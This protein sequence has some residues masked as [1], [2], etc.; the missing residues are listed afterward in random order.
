MTTG[1]YVVSSVTTADVAPHERAEFWSEHIMA[2]HVLLDWDFP[3]T[4]D[5]RGATVRQS[6]DT[7]QLMRWS[8]DHDHRLSRTPRQVRQDPDDDYRL[9][10]LHAGDAVVRQGDDQ[11]LL[12]TGTACLFPVSSPFVL[13]YLSPQNGLVMTIP[14]RELDGPLNRKTPLATGLDLST[15]LGRVVGNMLTR[16]HE[17][18]DILGC[19][20]FDAVADRIVELVCMLAVGDDRPNAPGLLAE[21]ESTVRRY[22]R[23]HA[24]EPEL[25]G[26]ALAR[27]LGW[28]LGQI[29]KALADAGT[30]A[31]ELI[32]EE[33]LRWVRSQLQSPVARHLTIADLA[34]RSGYA[35]EA[36]F[37]A[38]FR[39]RFG[40]SPCQMRHERGR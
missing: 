40:M 21:V 23:R 18:R 11:T 32:R 17:E 35:S 10:F 22:I 9:L 4:D 1:L 2:Q 30:T 38:A 12:A 15:G 6:T 14:A 27:G 20:Q 29:E 34:Y 28:P 37:S 25:S 19:K 7:Y 39:E 16:L 36:A 8:T 26:E 31:Q 3:R 5:F 24:G 13:D 33:R